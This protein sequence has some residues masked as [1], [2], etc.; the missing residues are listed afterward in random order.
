MDPTKLDDLTKQVIIKLHE[1]VF[2]VESLNQW[3]ADIFSLIN[4]MSEQ[5][6][7]FSP[8]EVQESCSLDPADKQRARYLAHKMLDSSLD[9]MQ[10]LH[11]QPVRRW[12]SYDVRSALE[13][14]PIPKQGQSLASVCDD[15]LQ[16]VIPYSRGNAHPRFWAWAV[17]EGTFGGTI[18]EMIASSLNMNVCDTDHSGAFVERAVIKWMHQLFGFPEET[19]R[20][21]LV[22]GTSMAT[23]I[24]MAVARQRV[25]PNVR[26]NGMANGCQLIV[27]AS[28]ETHTCVVKALELLGF[29]SK[30]LHLVPVDEHFR[31]NTSELKAAI[32]NDR[33]EGF[34]P[35]CIV[36]N[37]GKYKART[38]T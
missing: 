31:I 5:K 32:Q 4:S 15:I 22:T 34:I 17:G 27:Y 29:G 3:K 10:S 33:D 21:L 30:A 16:Y 1:S 13:N 9:Y 23:I 20:G 8:G 25:L 19:T 12:A 36:G 28:T 18:A 14:E 38:S 7:S 2:D 6:L 24:S 35:F 37:A 11:D 26:Q